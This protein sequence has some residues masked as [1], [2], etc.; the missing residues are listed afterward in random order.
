MRILFLAIAFS[1]QLSDNGA[2]GIDESMGSLVARGGN[3]LK[4]GIREVYVLLGEEPGDFTMEPKAIVIVM[5]NAQFKVFS[6]QAEHNR[7]R[8]FLNRFAWSELENGVCFRNGEFRLE[9]KT[10]EMM[11]RGWAHAASIPAILGLLRHQYYSQLFFLDK[12]IEMMSQ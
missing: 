7:F 2:S 4:D 3:W 1:R 6:V 11:Q 5:A 9:R 12:Q 8:A 10:E